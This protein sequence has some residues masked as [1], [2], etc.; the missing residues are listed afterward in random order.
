MADSPSE[1]LQG[2]RW[3]QHLWV[4]LLGLLGAVISGIIVAL[5]T[6][7]LED[8]PSPRP[9]LTIEKLVRPFAQYELQKSYR[10]IE[11][12]LF[13][14]CGI[15]SLDSGDPQALKCSAGND[16]Y[17]PCWPSYG[18][19]NDVACLKSPWEPE[20][21]ILA[22]AT[23]TAPSREPNPN[24]LPW[25]LEIHDPYSKSTLHCSPIP[26]TSDVIADMRVN[27]DCTYSGKGETDI[28]GY[29]IG[30]PTVHQEKPWTIRYNKKGSPETVPANIIVV[31][32]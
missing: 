23:I 5:V 25:A 13:S 22:N 28:Q 6:G 8:K 21:T 18:S 26:G 30:A 32:R 3:W 15:R 1:I 19:S 10:V 11:R 27:W 14:E 24:L 29:A 7:W 17:D 20:V 9:Q 4:W 16:L 12:R 2:K 31:W